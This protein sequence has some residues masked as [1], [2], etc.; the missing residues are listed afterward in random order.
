MLK[1]RKNSIGDTDSMHE[2]VEPYTFSD[3]LKYLKKH[4]IDTTKYKYE[5][6]A[7]EYERYSNGDI[8]TIKFSCPGDYLAY[9]AMAVHEP[10]TPEVIFDFFYEDY[11]IDAV[12]GIFEELPNSLSGMAD[13]ASSGWWGDGSDYIYYLKNLTTGNYLYKSHD[14]Y[15]VEE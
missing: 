15:L 8:Y 13:Y 12:D 1:I 7:Q 11:G 2:N 5:M 4:G 14:S 9:I 6:A 10:L 3:I